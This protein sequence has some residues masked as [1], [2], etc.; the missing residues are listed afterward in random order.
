VRIACHFRESGAEEKNPGR[1][2]E[3]KSERWSFEKWFFKRKKLKVLGV[4]A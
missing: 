1:G 4:S 3:E 2:K